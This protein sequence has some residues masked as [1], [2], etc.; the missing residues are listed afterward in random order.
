MALLA[1]R[2]FA[3]TLYGVVGDPIAFGAAVSVLVTAATA[4][5]ISRPAAPRGRSGGGVA[6][7]LTD[8]ASRGTSPARYSHLEQACPR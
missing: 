4:S 3:G 7:T 8:A 2:V 1:S 5:A 6:A